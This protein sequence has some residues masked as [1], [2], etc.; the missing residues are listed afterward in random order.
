M[1]ATNDAMFTTLRQLYPTVAPSLGDLLAHHWAV[2]GVRG[3]AQYDYYK[4]F[5]GA[6]GETWGDLANWYWNDA[7]T[8]VFNLEL[9]DGNDLLLEDG[10]LI[11]LE[12]GNV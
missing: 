11:M 2:V 3:A 5:V 4:S 9:E 8:A 12:A 10:N 7:D 6:E 1:T